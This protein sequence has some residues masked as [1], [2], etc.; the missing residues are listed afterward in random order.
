[1]ALR[2][3]RGTDSERQLITPAE[4][5]LIYTTDT[6]KLWSGDGT[7]QGGVLVSAGGSSTSL[8]ALTDT[9]LVGVSNSDVLS[10]NASSNKWESTA[11]PGVGT[12]SLNN[13]TDVYIQEAPSNMEALVFDGANW[14]GRPISDF[15]T[16]QQNYKINIVGDDST[17]MVDTDTGNLTGNLTGN[18]I[19]NVTGNLTGNVTGEQNINAVGAHTGTLDGDVTG[20]VFA[21]DSTLLVD[22]VNGNIPANVLTGAA[23][24]NIIGN[25]DGAHTGSFRGEVSGSVF[26]DDSS[27]IIDGVN[28]T[29]NGSLLG[30]VTGSIKSQ[31]G[32]VIIANGTDGTDAAFTGTLNG[33]IKSQG[34]QVIIANGTDG[35]DAVFTGTLNGTFNGPSAGTHTGAVIGDVTGNASGSH[36]GSLDGHITGSVFGDDST[37]IIDGINNTISTVAILAEVV[38]TSTI[39]ATSATQTVDIN[40]QYL[41]VEDFG[42]TGSNGDATT[43][44]TEISR[45]TVDAPVTMQVGDFIGAFTMS[46]YNGTAMAVKSQIATIVDT[47]TG[48]NALP[49]KMAL[50]IHNFDSGYTTSATLDSRGTFEAPTFKATPYADAAARDAQVGTAE[51]GMIIYLTDTNK[52]QCY[53]GTTWTNL[54]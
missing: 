52:L 38:N 11:V 27:L 25:A 2:L 9:N 4:G 13:L 6:K 36:I 31:G 51:A 33:S 22:G 29:L 17:I 23:T 46:G 42:G 15:F 14:T 43:I 7:T 20:S 50:T 35:T 54:F 53:N 45:G 34:G 5:E 12:I 41:I 32:Q 40:A 28:N 30:N 1:M 19:G 8:D 49:T 16:E 44:G 10:F 26:G 39:T 48:T 47:V 37:L 18:V 24:I 3:R 21:D